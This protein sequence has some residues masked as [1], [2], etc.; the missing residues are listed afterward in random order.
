MNTVGEDD[1]ATRIVKHTNH[2]NNNSNRTSTQHYSQ[3]LHSRQQQQKMSPTTETQCLKEK[4]RAEK[5]AVEKK[6]TE[7]KARKAPNPTP[8]RG[9]PTAAARLIASPYIKFGWHKPLTGSVKDVIQSLGTVADSMYILQIDRVRPIEAI[10]LRNGLFWEHR[11]LSRPEMLSTPAVDHIDLF[12]ADEESFQ[13]TLEKIGK[14]ISSDQL[15]LHCLF[16]AIRSREFLLLPVQLGDIWNPPKQEVELT[17]MVLYADMKVTDL[18]LVDPLPE[19]R[20]ARQALINSRLES[21]FPEGC[22][23]SALD[24]KVRNFAVP[25]IVADNTSNC[26]WQTGLIAYA[27]SREFIRRLKVLQ[28]RH[29]RGDGTCD[30]QDFLWAPFEEQHNFD[31]YRQ[32]LLAAC[33]HQ[34]IEGS[35]FQARIA[36]EV[37]SEDSN[38]Q[39]ELLGGNRPNILANDEKW[40]IFQ[41][42]THTHAIPIYSNDSS[43]ACEQ[44]VDPRDLDPT[45]PLPAEV[46]V[47]VE[48][49][50]GNDSAIQSL[51][52]ASEVDVTEEERAATPNTPNRPQEPRSGGSRPGEYA[53]MHKRSRAEDD[54]VEAAPSPK[55][56]K[57]TEDAEMNS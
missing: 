32:N 41:T 10:S 1:L 7:K 16:G 34:C 46:K 29:D 51:P 40:N 6:T 8:K 22:I 23:E 38:Y 42:E 27:V 53:G 36:L 55:R 33:A 57:Q 43:N 20:E 26:H 52:P 47:K 48:D 18:A 21:I 2:T 17:Q 5:K 4:K 39:R 3:H 28:Y 12:S 25:D 15:I 30:D 24:L 19:G 54:N 56:V 49:E 11:Q 45:Y 35:G 37:P 13:E 44:P 9:Q 14:R 31:T 50:D